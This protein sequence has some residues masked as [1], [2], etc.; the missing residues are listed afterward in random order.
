VCMAAA[1]GS[2]ACAADPPPPELSSLED[3]AAADGTAIGLTDPEP[4]GEKG[5]VSMQAGERCT[6]LVTRQ[7]N[8]VTIANL[9][10]PS[11]QVKLGDQLPTRE[12]MSEILAKY[13][14]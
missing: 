7:L 11:E 10:T 14:C 12:E 1:M 9:I 5:Q 2:T 3:I 8:N 6:A 4:T 13:G